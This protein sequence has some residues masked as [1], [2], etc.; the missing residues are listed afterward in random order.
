MVVDEDGSVVGLVT[1]ED[2]VEEIVGDIREEGETAATLI[3]RLRGHCG[4]H[5]CHA[6]F[7]A[8]PG[9]SFVAADHRWTVVEMEALASAESSIR[10]E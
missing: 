10:P 2:V 6:R 5:P 1:V 4:I 7:R 9:T 3:A 8:D